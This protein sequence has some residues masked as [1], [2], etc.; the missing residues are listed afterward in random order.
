MPKPGREHIWVVEMLL[1]GRWRATD[2]AS[3]S[4]TAGRKDL[5]SWVEANPDIRFRLRRYV[6]AGRA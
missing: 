2:G 6:P 5:N 3:G 4:R 1:D